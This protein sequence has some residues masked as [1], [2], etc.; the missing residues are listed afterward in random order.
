[1]K[2][3]I[4]GPESGK[5]TVTLHYIYNEIAKLLE[6]Q[7]SAK[8][9]AQKG[10]A[11]S[12]TVHHHACL[13]TSKKKM[14]ESKMIFGIYCEVSI[15]TLREVKLKYIE[16]YEGLVQFLCDFHLLPVKPSILAI[17]SLEYFVDN[18]RQGI[19]Q[20]TKQMRFNFLMTLIKDC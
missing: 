3:I 10:G 16:D 12:S 1:M 6:T 20:L 4:G 7:G 2:V 19:N 15:E 17:D 9:T 13:V 8:S 11:E 5:T 18:K 14:I